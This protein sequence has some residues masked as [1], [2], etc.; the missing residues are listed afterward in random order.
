MAFELDEVGLERAA[1]QLLLDRAP[2]IASRFAEGGPMRGEALGLTGAP[3]VT[4]WDTDQA[5]R[6]LV[7][8]LEQLTEAQTATLRTLLDG[9]GPVTVKTDPSSA[10]TLACVFRPGAEVEAV[11]GV[12]PD[13]APAG[14]RYHRAT[15]PLF[16]LE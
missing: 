15:V 12:Y 7:L 10:D 6:E 9:T 14:L 4:E 8:V 3:I 16:I 11:I 2:R 5:R 1:T 13:N